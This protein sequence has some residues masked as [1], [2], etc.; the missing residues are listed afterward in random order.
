LK[1]ID[2][3]NQYMEKTQRFH[4]TREA[5]LHLIHTAVDE[6]CTQDNLSLEKFK[7]ILNDCGC[8]K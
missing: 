7:C 1:D 4:E 6:N 2:K 5:W 3:Y 8:E